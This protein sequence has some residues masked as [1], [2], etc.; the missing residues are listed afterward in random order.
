MLYFYKM[1]YIIALAL[2][3]ILLAW[4]VK[5]YHQ[6]AEL[7]RQLRLAWLGAIASIKR[8]NQVLQSLLFHIAGAEHDDV[9]LRQLRHAERDFDI[10]LNRASKS[11]GMDTPLLHD[12]VKSEAQLQELMH[13]LFLA[14]QESC[15]SILLH[16]YHN[17]M[18]VDMSRV[19]QIRLY[20]A[21]A[22]HYNRSLAMTSHKL[23]VN[24]FHIQAANLLKA[25][26]LENAQVPHAKLLS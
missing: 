5:N 3:L 18:Q 11:D 20:N 17:L 21:Q 26:A 8:R 24:L 1:Q 15:D 4:G 13:Q 12:I 22:E 23:I 19:E 16:A 10:Q 9:L 7:Q 25:Q 2:L 14:H 6:F